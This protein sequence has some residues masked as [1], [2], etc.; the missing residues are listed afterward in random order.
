MVGGDQRPLYFHIPKTHWPPFSLTKCATTPRI[1]EGPEIGCDFDKDF[2]HCVVEVW[3]ELQREA[4]SI[5]R[6]ERNEDTITLIP[7]PH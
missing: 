6:K 1:S 3:A 2:Q 5:N 4:S 7:K